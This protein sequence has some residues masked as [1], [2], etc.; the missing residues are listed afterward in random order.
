MTKEIVPRSSAPP[1]FGRTI[2]LGKTFAESHLF[3]DTRSAAQAFVK[4]MA[5]RDLGLGAF[6]AMAGIHIIAGRI[7]ISANAI[8]CCIRRSDRYDYR[9][10][11]HDDQAC[12]IEFLRDG[13]AIGTSTFTMADAKRAGLDSN[14]NWRKYPRNMLFARAIS[15]GA[16]WYC[17]DLFGGSP[18]YTPDELNAEVDGETGDVVAIRRDGEAGGLAPQILDAERIRTLE[19][20]LQ[21]KGVDPAGFLGHYGIEDL[22][23]LTE[24]QHLD[25]VTVLAHKPDPIPGTSGAGPGADGGVKKEG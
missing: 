12:E 16:R 18:V 17:P 9:V 25:A 7:T 19:S 20:L 14:T 21:R 4:I 8:A 10:M 13:Q 22:G 24:V 6:A 3:A 5:G 11:R 2:N 1:G 15:N 23:E